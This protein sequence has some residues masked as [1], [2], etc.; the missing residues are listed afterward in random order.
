MVEELQVYVYSSIFGW[1][2][3]SFKK[4]REIKTM[5]KKIYSKC[6]DWKL[7]L[8]ALIGVSLKCIGNHVFIGIT[9]HSIHVKVD[10]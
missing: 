10:V 2:C 5:R 6:V 7:I 8:N 1:L 3:L 4:A 9:E